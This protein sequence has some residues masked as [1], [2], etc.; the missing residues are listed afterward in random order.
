MRKLFL[1]LP[2][3]VLSL[4]A[5]AKTINIAPGVNTIRYA[6]AASTTVDGDVLILADGTYTDNNY[7]EFNKSVEIQAAEGATPIV[8]LHTYI[9]Y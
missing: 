3:L 5:N 7:I 6:L 4:F 2:A 9:K 1:L 8:Q